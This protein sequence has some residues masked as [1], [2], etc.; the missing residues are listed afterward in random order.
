MMTVNDNG[1]RFA[2]LFRQGVPAPAGLRPGLPYLAYLCH[3]FIVTCSRIATDRGDHAARLR[4][5]CVIPDYEGGTRSR[6]ES[7]DDVAAD[8]YRTRA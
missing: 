6:A 3:K 8:P 7:E 2:D 1:K 4:N 5:G